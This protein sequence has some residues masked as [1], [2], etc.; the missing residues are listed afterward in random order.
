[1]LAIDDVQWCDEASANLL[2]Y[3]VRSKW[4]RP[5]VVIMAARD[6]ELADNPTMLA[7]LRSLRHGRLLQEIE[8]R[9]P[10]RG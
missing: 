3:M 4:Q 9:P 1:M 2:H 7:V 6:G 8:T 5:F 10:A